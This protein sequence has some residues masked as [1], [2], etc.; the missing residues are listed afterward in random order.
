MG[1]PPAGGRSPQNKSTN[2]SLPIKNDD[3]AGTPAKAID[4][5]TVAA[6]DFADLLQV[7]G[8]F[9]TVVAELFAVNV[10][11][12]QMKKE[13]SALEN[14]T[15]VVETELWKEQQMNADMRIK[16]A[17]LQHQMHANSVRLDQCE[18]YN[19]PFIRE[20]ERRRAQSAARGAETVHIFK[21]S[22]R[23]ACIARSKRTKASSTIM[24]WSSK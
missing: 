12:E 9:G 13:K 22:N 10:E 14:K 17:E 23:L 15:Q 3:S 2:N 19:H 7:K 11:L 1:V 5:K 16:V 8:L 6:V 24:H 20:M 4:S 21:R 18:T